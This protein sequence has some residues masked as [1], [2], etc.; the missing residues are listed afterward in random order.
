VVWILAVARLSIEDEARAVM[1][2]TLFDIKWVIQFLTSGNF[3]FPGVR[4][5]SWISADKVCCRFADATDAYLDRIRKKSF[6]Y[7]LF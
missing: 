6:P 7:P 1:T 3:T 4:V 2:S 5:K